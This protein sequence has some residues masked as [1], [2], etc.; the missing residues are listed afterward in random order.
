MTLPAS[1][2][3]ALDAIDDVLESAEPR[4]AT[5]F[6][7]FTDLTRLTAMPAVETLP[8]GRWRLRHWLPGP[9][10]QPGWV[11]QPR[12]RPGL[13][14]PGPGRRLGRIALMPLLLVA[15]VSLL[16]VSLV[17]SAPAGRRGCGQAVVAA[18]A[19]RLRG[20]ASHTAG[21]GGTAGSGT[22]GAPGSAGCPVAGVWPATG[23]R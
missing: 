21:S 7:V 14:R 1:Q 20:T 15:A 19:S 10:Y 2:Q 18:M 5:M 16:I 3:R 4:L 13:R 8:P 11:V 9:R 12:Y 23:G 22:S 6:S 17:S